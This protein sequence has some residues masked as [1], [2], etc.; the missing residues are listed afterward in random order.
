MTP[1]DLET[2]A[3]PP[4]GGA[5]LPSEADGTMAPPDAP[6][7]DEPVQGQAFGDHWQA[8]PVTQSGSFS[9][10][11]P[12]GGRPDGPPPLRRTVGQPPPPV[13]R[14]FAPPPPPAREGGRRSFLSWPL[15]ILILG[16]FSIGSC[17]YN[18]SSI[19]SG[20]SFSRPG[21][22]SSM[23]GPGVAVLAIEGEIFDTRWAMAALKSFEENDH[24]KAIVLRVDSP[25][26]A[27]AP[28]Q[29]LYQALKAFSKPVVVSMG[30]VAASGGLYLAMAGSHVMAN[31][32]TITGSIGVIMETLEVAGAM[33][34]LGL[35]AQVI[36][37]GQ[38]K[39]IGSPFR[40]M[41]LE[42]QALLQSMV[43]EVYEQFLS[44]VV[45]GRPKLSAEQVRAM[46]DGRVFSG[47][48]ALRAGL[49]DSLGGLKEAL[50]Q[51]MVR[52]GIADP[53]N[54]QVIYEDGRGSLLEDLVGSRLSFLDKVDSSVQATPAL[55][56]IYRPGLF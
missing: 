26:G 28:C 50:E 5:A 31:P 53:S 6:G 15:V 35:K 30:S 40:P 19:L 7:L 54:A 4:E 48:A 12:L 34:K 22:V 46:A 49:I 11:Q 17:S 56:F 43:L 37:S 9:S 14:S 51:A 1:D 36:K 20:L 45:A 21:G 18:V 52:G 27:V 2:Q 55:K 8:S 33:D 42:E 16:F 39:D 29:E 25:G 10:G 24:V 38:Y 23:T 3:A 32:G 44:D 41:G 13:R 47:Q